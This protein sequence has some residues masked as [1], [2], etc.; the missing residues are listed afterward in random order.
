MVPQILAVT[1]FLGG[2]IL[3]ISGA[4]PAVHSRLS[5]LEDFLP[6]P[7]IEFSHFLGSLAGR[8]APLPR[9][10]PPAPARRRLSAHRGRCSAAASSSRS[11][12]A[13]DWE[14]ALILAL[15]LAA[16]AALPPPLLP[17]GLAHRRAVHAGLERRHRHRRSLG[18]LWLGLLRLQ[19]RRLLAR[20]LVALHLP[21]RRAALPARLCRRRGAC[22][23]SSPSA[24]AAPGRPEPA[25][26]TDEELDARRG[27]SPRAA[28]RTYAYLA[29]L[30]DKELLFNDDR[31]APS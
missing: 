13:L 29:L 5:W 20:A 9:H 21:R 15:M 16:L 31:H 27:A 22:C 17:Q 12:R 7:V 8:G 23:C 24:P 10:R 3:L 1:T 14:E 26:P 30:G 4:T 19:A 28:P 2:A 6:L 11:P 18:S 25:P